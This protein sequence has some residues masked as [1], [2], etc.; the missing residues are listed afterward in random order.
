M[1]VVSRFRAVE[2]LAGPLQVMRSALAAMPGYVSGSLGRNLDDPDLWLLE[3]TWAD[4][5]S[6]RRALSAYDVKV[7]VAPVMVHALD[8][9]SAYE[10]VGA[11]RETNEQRPRTLD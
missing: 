11:G 3:T 8:E 2:D 10:P 7:A 4:V 5:G 1:I 9:P 6:Y